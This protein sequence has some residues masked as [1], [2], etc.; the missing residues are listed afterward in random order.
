MNAFFETASDTSC[1]VA[2]LVGLAF[3]GAP[4]HDQEGHDTVRCAGGICL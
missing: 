3:G 2:I 1:K 4:A